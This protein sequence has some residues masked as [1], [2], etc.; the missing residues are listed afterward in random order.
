MS[1]SSMSQ[2]VAPKLNK[3]VTA[4]SNNVLVKTI[5]AGMA[6]LLARF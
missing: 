2:K 5:A 3:A 1:F 4:F 6:R